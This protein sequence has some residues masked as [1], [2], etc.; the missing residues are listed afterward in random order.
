MEE[1]QNVAPRPML[2]FTPEEL[3]EDVE[4]LS[5][6]PPEETDH[7]SSWKMGVQDG[8]SGYLER[9]GSRNIPTSATK[10]GKSFIEAGQ[11]GQ[12][13]GECSTSYSG[14]EAH[15]CMEHDLM[16]AQDASQHW[17][18]D[19]SEEHDLMM[20]QDTNPP[21]EED[22]F[23]DHDSMLSEDQNQLLEAHCSMKHDSLT[24]HDDEQLCHLE[25]VDEGGSLRN[26]QGG[27]GRQGPSQPAAE[28]K[29]EGFSPESA[30]VVQT[31]SNRWPAA[32]VST[33]QGLGEI[34]LPA[35]ETASQ[36]SSALPLGNTTKDGADP[37]EVKPREDGNLPWDRV[38]ERKSPLPPPPP[39]QQGSDSY[40]WNHYYNNP[41]FCGGQQPE[42]NF[43]LSL[44]GMN[45]MEP[46]CTKGKNSSLCG[47]QIDDNFLLSMQ[48]MSH[49]ELNCTKGTLSANFD[50]SKDRE[51]DPASVC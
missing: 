44:Q 23:M 46:N 25:T 26:S 29:H 22:Y 14:V 15:Y 13:Q 37:P 19:H 32:C 49:I 12:E 21:F 16:L 10:V 40:E 6:P 8:S 28:G 18:A 17:E 43:L 1:R 33:L 34:C 38:D 11:K 20:A 7:P 39:Q 51:C 27:E 3:G 24:A 31:E 45:H 30:P 50:D 36:L 5:C 9:T 41:S 42:D 47:Q 4:S 35:W 48:R 2:Q